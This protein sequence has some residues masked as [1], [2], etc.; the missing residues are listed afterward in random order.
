[1]IAL[2]ELLV[3]LGVIAMMIGYVAFLR[4]LLAHADGNGHDSHDSRQKKA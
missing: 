2:P 1:M 4:Y 3:V